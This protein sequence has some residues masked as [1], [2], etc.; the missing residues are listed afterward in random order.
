MSL[1]STTFGA[2]RTPI[3]EAL[4]GAKYL[5]L[6]FCRLDYWLISD[7]L[8]DLVSKVDILASIKTDH[9]STVLELEDIQEGFRGPGFWKLNTSLLTRPD[10]VDMINNEV[11]IWLEEANDLS[12]PLIG[13][14]MTDS[15][16]EAF[17]EKEMLLHK[18]KLS[19]ESKGQKLFRK[20][21][22]YIVNKC[23]CQDCF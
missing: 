14:L 2:L 23:G 10:Y 21:E 17:D 8:H 1:V 4:R 22:P 18:S 6:N 3:L 12:R 11:P 5:H 16:N 19:S 9:S 20:L 15:F 7:N 13:K